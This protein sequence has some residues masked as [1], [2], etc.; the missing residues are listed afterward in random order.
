MR[1]DI[2][3]SKL[4]PFV[5]AFTDRALPVSSAAQLARLIA[6]PCAAVFPGL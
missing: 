4:T 6:L 1:Q 5:D 2:D 3:D